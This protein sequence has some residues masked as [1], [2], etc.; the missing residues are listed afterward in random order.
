MEINQEQIKI[1]L[2]VFEE[3]NEMLYTLSKGTMMTEEFEL[4]ELLK[5][6]IK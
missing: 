1:M 5:E 3:Y 6:K 2:E 4:Y